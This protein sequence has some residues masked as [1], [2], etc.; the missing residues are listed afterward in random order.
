MVTDEEFEA[1]NARAA[2]RRRTTPWAVRARYDRRLRR[3]VVR[4]SSGMDLTFAPRDVQGLEHAT[5]DQLAD[6]EVAGVGYGLHWP[7]IDADVYVPS[8]LQGITGSKAW[9]EKRRSKLQAAE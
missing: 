2:E 7:G 4:L 8:L 1:A 5:P 9:M 3:V 6:V